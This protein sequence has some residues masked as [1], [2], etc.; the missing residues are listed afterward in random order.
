MKKLLKKKPQKFIFFACGE[1]SCVSAYRSIPHNMVPSFKRAS[2]TTLPSFPQVSPIWS[3]LPGLGG[4][5]FKNSLHQW[6]PQEKPLTIKGTKRYMKSL[7]KGAEEAHENYINKFFNKKIIIWDKWIISGPK[8][9]HSGNS[10]STVI[11]HE[12]TLKTY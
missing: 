2:S 4:H 9:A 6:Q 10:E 11:V 3:C 1:L 7:L 12:L 5:T 8:L